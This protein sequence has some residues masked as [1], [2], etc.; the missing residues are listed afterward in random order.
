MDFAQEEFLSVLQLENDNHV[1]PSYRETW[2]YIL[3]TAVFI[4]V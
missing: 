2:R 4:P 1:A 3:G